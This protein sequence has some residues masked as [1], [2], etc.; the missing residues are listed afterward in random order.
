MKQHILFD[1]VET[2]TILFND[3]TSSAGDVMFAV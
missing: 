2:T 3:T 1:A